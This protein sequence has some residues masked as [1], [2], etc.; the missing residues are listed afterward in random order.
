[1]TSHTVILI[2]VWV[3]CLVTI[4]STYSHGRKSRASE[5]ITIYTVILM[6]PLSGLKIVDS[7]TSKDSNSRVLK[8]LEK[9][10][11]SWSILCK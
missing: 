10:L 1:M 11:E 8:M 7:Q 2:V 6:L 3:S 5:C 9:L 4:E